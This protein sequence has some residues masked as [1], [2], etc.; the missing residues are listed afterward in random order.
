MPFLVVD[1][2]HG[3]GFILRMLGLVLWP[4]SVCLLVAFS[5]FSGSLYWPSE[6]RDLGVEGCP[7]SSFSSFLSFGLGSVGQFRCRLLLWVLAS[8]FGN[9]V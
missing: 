2:Y 5:A 4:Y 6:V 9:I 7:T 8:T 3:A 1:G